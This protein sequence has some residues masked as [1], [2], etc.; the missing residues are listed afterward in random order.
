[1][2]ED[3]NKDCKICNG[4]GEESFYW[5]NRKTKELWIDWGY[6]IKCFPGSSYYEDPGMDWERTNE[7]EYYKLKK[8]KEYKVIDR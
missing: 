7:D 8:N 3:A 1:M 6:C 4:S 5:V 2:Q